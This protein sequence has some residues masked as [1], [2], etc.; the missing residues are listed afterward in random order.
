[1]QLSCMSSIFCF[2]T[3][4]VIKRRS[5]CYGLDTSVLILSQEIPRSLQ[6]NTGC[7]TALGYP[8]GKTLLLKTSHTLAEKAVS[9]Q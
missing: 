3:K 8:L 6:N 1:M 9:E 5:Q 2:N 4:L 7:N